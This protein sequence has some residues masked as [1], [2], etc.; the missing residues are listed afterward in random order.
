MKS[1]DVHGQ[2]TSPG[3]VRFVRIL[4]APIERV[5]EYLTDPAKRGRWLARGHLT[6]QVGGENH[7]EFHNTQL[8]GQPEQITPKYQKDAADGCGFTGH[9]TRW[10]P[11]HVLA[12]TWG[13]EDG[14]IS[15]VTFELSESAGAV[16]LVLTHRRLGDSRDL[17]LSAAAGW[18]THLDILAAQLNGVA[19]PLFWTTHERLEAEYGRRFSDDGAGAQR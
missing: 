10:E 15:E 9:I 1:H 5:W 3:E 16:T 6:P 18:H 8:S 19:P 2:L 7:L 12:H 14:S 4:P 11:P 13:E 17:L